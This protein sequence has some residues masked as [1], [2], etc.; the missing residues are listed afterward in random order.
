M[1]CNFSRCHSSAKLR[2]C[3]TGD[4]WH[5][6]RPRWQAVVQQP[7]DDA[8]PDGTSREANNAP[9]QINIVGERRQLPAEKGPSSTARFIVSVRAAVIAKNAGDA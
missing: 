4:G 9:I 6:R 8:V 5:E 1:L 7:R 3:N 2:A